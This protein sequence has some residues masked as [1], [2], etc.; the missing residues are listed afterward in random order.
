MSVFGNAVGS[1][2]LDTRAR[3]THGA[4]SL[5]RGGGESVIDLCMKVNNLALLLAFII[6]YGPPHTQCMRQSDM[7]EYG[8]PHT[9]CMRQS[10]MIE[11][12]PPH[13]QCMRQS[14]V[15]D[16]GPPHTQCMRQSDSRLTFVPGVS[17]RFRWMRPHRYCLFTP[18]LKWQ[19]R[20]EMAYLTGVPAG[21]AWAI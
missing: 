14:D 8:P 4:T 15:I 19:P 20:G 5:C 12:G 2:P 6:D 21:N 3:K 10:D 7:I 9:Q 18:E 16:Y 11:Y 1:A 17:E 13:T